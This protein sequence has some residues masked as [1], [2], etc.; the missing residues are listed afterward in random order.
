MKKKDFYHATYWLEDC[1]HCRLIIHT[2]ATNFNHLLLILKL[3]L[4]SP[5]YYTH[6]H[7]SKPTQRSV[8]LWPL[9][10]CAL[11]NFEDMELSGVLTTDKYLCSVGLHVRVCDGCMLLRVKASITMWLTF[12]AINGGTNSH[13]FMFYEC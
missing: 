5:I 4:Y 3:F 9:E 7:S 11:A 13:K 12:N 10:H 1:R 8:S 6:T 2:P